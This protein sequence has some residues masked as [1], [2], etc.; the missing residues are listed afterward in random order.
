MAENAYVTRSEL[1]RRWQAVRRYMDENGVD[2][3]VAIARDDYLGGYVKWFT[4]VSA[5][6][7]P[8]ALAFYR[9]G[10]M[11]VVEH[12]PTGDR[13]TLDGSHEAYPGVG[14][15]L[16][17]A[18]FPSAAQTSGYTGALIGQALLNR[19]CRRV[20]LAG[21]GA[22]PQGFV[23]AL[24]AAAPEALALDA[25]E[26]LDHEKALKSVEELRL[27]R[28]TAHM[29]DA[30]FE[31]LLPRIKPGMR[32]FEITALARYEG[33]LLGSEQG[34]FM[35]RSAALGA[36]LPATRGP[37]FDTRPLKAGD[38]MSV[39]IENNGPAG[40][41]TELGRTIVLGPAHSALTDAFEQAVEAQRQT[42][43]S[44]RRGVTG[45]DVY[46]QHANV[47]KSLGQTPSRR[48]FSH[49]QGFDLV[50]RP[51]IR[52]DESMAI[53]PGM[54]FAIHPTIVREGSAA[55]VCDNFV[56]TEG[57]GEWLHQTPKKVFEI[58]A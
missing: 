33:A 50:E 41:Y 28:A 17:T 12:G 47:M 15:V 29:Q 36:P 8:K 58:A 26:F 42:A 21:R 16:T 39:L 6:L 37:H 56:V 5:F 7:Y 48:I 14:E 32:Q 49:G 38:Y 55:F 10:L 9:S 57:A 20:A 31:R 43:K 35:C 1:E 40:Y 45:A 46:A 54:C 53:E 13:R 22:M 34:V 2:A 25:T 11:T 19:G 30:I 4:N 3:I 24:K 51:L 27:L 52:E 23:E 18:E 44:M